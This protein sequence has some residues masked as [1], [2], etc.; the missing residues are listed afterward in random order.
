MT[1]HNLFDEE[2]LSDVIEAVQRVGRRLAAG[3]YTKAEVPLAKAGDRYWLIE[4]Y[5]NP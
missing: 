4:M 2:W 5:V 1:E 3:D